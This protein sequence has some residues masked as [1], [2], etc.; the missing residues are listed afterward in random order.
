MATSLRSPLRGSA[1]SLFL[2]METSCW[3]RALGPGGWRHGGPYEVFTTLCLEWVK[4]ADTREL[5]VE[6]DSWGR[7]PPSQETLES[8]CE[9]LETDARPRSMELREVPEAGSWALFQ[10]LSPDKGL[11]SRNM[12]N[13]YN[14]T[15]K[16]QITQFF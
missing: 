9:T 4:A 5:E 13:C 14:S 11:V 12:K 3:P 7:C 6:S 16:G 10:L 2:D 8:L 15:I 1:F